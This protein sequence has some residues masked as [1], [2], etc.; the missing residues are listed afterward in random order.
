MA[1]ER[2]KASEEIVANM[3]L[4]DPGLLLRQ[5]RNDL[6]R[7]VDKRRVKRTDDRVVR[8]E[9]LP[10]GL[11]ELVCPIVEFCSGS[12]LDFRIQ[13]AKQ[14]QGW[15]VNRFKF[16]LRFSERVIKMVR[17]HLNQTVGHNPV[18][19]PRCHLHVGDSKAHNPFR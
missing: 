15:L 14:Q 19:V 3:W 5:L 10:L 1:R 13:L 17:I 6:G 4:E 12:K 2:E 7:Q 9:P 18:A 8:L 11:A 16:H